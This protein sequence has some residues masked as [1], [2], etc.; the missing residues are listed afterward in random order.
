MVHNF[1]NINKWNELSSSYKLIVRAA[2]ALA[3]EWCWRN[4][5]L[6]IPQR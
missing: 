2:S 6:T 5:M 4:T 1:I 3:N